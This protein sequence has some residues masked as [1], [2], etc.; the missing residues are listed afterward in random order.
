MHYQQ[1]TPTAAAAN[2]NATAAFRICVHENSS[3]ASI[4]LQVV[5]ER[6]LGIIRN[7]Y[8]LDSFFTLQIYDFPVQAREPS[9]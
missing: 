2:T 9:V 6:N 5:L 8:V 3:F 1:F 4:A 7:S